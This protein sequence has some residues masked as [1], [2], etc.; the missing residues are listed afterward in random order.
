MDSPFLRKL[1]LV[2]LFPNRI[3]HSE[4]PKKFCLQLLVAFGLDIFA[5]Q[6]NFLT[7]GVA[8]RLDSFIV[9]LFLKFLGMMKIFL[10]DNH[11]LSEFR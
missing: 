9:S 6:P 2:Y 8:S 3:E 10:A 11:Q 1:Q 4:R 5:V 7:E